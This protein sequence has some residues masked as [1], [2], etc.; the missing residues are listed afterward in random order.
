[1]AN[2]REPGY[3]PRVARHLR[4]TVAVVTGASS[5]I[6]R[7]AA[8]RF[9]D[10]GAAVVVTARRQAPLEALAAQ[11]EAHGGRALA[12]VADVRDAH[13]LREVA[14]RAQ[15]QL[16]GLDVWAN[17]AGVAAFGA[18]EQLSPDLFAG[19]VE[20][21]LLGVVHG[22]RA[23]LPHLRARGGVLVN[24]SSVLGA[25]PAP[26]LTPYIASKYA[27]RGF[28]AAL[29]EE[30]RGSGVAVCT[31][32]PGPFDTPIWQHAANRSGRR[33][34]ALR[35]TGDPERVGAAIVRAARRPRREVVVGRAS[36]LLVG[37]HRVLPAVTERLVGLDVRF[38]AF[39]DEPEPPNA[40]NVARPMDAYAGVRG[41][42]RRLRR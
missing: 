7:A 23:A 25:V 33:I 31:I 37:A 38:D 20:T 42:W 36:A 26:Y 13:A 22:T 17:V 32:L 24:V 18:F 1:M 5:G 15:A 2:T 34:R 14:R 9:A 8:L 27:I 41:G 6:G 29:R 35:P 11:I 39:G 30:L 40:G 16:G 3:V 21:N 10:A 12:V 28:S 4:N 19:V